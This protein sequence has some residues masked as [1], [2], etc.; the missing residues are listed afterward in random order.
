M[1]SLGSEIGLKNILHFDMLLQ[2]LC[3]DE[4][5]SKPTFEFVRGQSCLEFIRLIALSSLRH[6][7]DTLPPWCIR[8]FFLHDRSLFFAFS[9][10]LLMF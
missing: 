10:P 9:P 2:G 8:H 4:S 7:N 3:A 5:P 1:L 6:L